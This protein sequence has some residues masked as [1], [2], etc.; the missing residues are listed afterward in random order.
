VVFVVL[1]V[2]LLAA[3]AVVLI[4]H[5]N[6]KQTAKRDKPAKR[7]KAPEKRNGAP[8]AAGPKGAKPTGKTRLRS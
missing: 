2:L 3:G 5:F 7:K 4:V 1:A 8:A 6:R